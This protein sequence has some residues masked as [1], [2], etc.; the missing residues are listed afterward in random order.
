MG[1][2][3]KPTPFNP[4]TSGLTQEWRRLFDNIAR[5]IAP[6]WK[7]PVLDM[8]LLEGVVISST[9]ANIAH[10]LGRKWRGWYPVD[11]IEPYVITRSD[12][13]ASLALDPTIYLPLF[14]P[15]APAPF[16]VSL[17]VF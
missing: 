16:T 15:T 11:M 7:H 8:T 9:P 14:A 3:I 12:S 13:L 6:L 2:Y 10:G 5:T 1:T 17:V 4:P